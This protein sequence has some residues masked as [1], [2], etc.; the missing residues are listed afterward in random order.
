MDKET[1]LLG[2]IEEN[3]R[4]NSKLEEGLQKPRIESTTEDMGKLK[5]E[6]L[7]LKAS[8]IDKE[9]MLQRVSEEN[10]VMRSDIKRRDEI[11][12]ELEA[13]RN[14][15]KEALSKLNLIMEEVDK[16]NRRAARATEQLE[17]SKAS[18]SEMES[19]LRRLKVQSDQWR[20]AA[21]AATAM[22]SVGGNGKYV[23]RT[24]SLDSG[25]MNGRMGS[26]YADDGD[27]DLTKKNGSVLK[28]F[29]FL[30]RKPQK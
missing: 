4:L 5:E 18:A 28:K 13:T 29:G 16:S 10:E 14:A 17:A 25:Y 26:P 11:V 15:E 2:I 22:I 8:M 9:M 30:W 23:D 6:L 7:E 21:E 27:D 12:A 24:T 19:E 20:K 1:E 3:E